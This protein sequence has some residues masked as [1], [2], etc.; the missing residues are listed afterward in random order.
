MKLIRTTP[1]GEYY[2]MDDGRVGYCNHQYARISVARE[3]LRDGEFFR[4]ENE[5]SD[6]AYQINKKVEYTT[7][8]GFNAY[9]RIRY[10]NRTEAFL[11][12]YEYNLKNCSELAMMKRERDTYKSHYKGMKYYNT[13][14]NRRTFHEGIDVGKGEVINQLV[15]LIENIEL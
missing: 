4:E 15:K 14:R 8:Y 13:V 6:R 3:G 9:K 12:L 10:N 5:V 1:T 11:A 2:R 7:E